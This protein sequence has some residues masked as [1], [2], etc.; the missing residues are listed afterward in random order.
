MEVIKVLSEDQI[1]SLKTNLNTVQELM[2]KTNDNS[3]INDFFKETEPFKKTKYTMDNFELDMSSENPIDTD[4]INAKLIHEH[5]KHLPD[6]VLCDERLWVGLSFNKF[7]NY[8]MYRWNPLNEKSFT[9]LEYRWFFKFKYRRALFFHG[10]ARLFWLAK[11][12]YNEKLENPYEL[13]EFC[14]RHSEILERMIFR[15]YSC[16]SLVRLSII[17][18]I[19]KFIEDG[20]NFTHKMNDNIMK[21]M[22][23]LGGAFILDSFEEKE[24]QEKIYNKL[25]QLYIEEEPKQTAFKL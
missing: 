17:S 9:K 7:Y 24:L 16:S 12:S 25:I 15:N 14:F 10:L 1:I 6:S 23:F 19:K 5:L 13:T 20:G 2:K 22:S 3:W 8:L 21:Y 4:Y 18:A 11:F